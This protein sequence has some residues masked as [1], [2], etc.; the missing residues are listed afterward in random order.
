MPPTKKHKTILL[1]EDDRAL[2]RA[3]VFKLEQDGHKVITTYSAEDALDILEKET[4]HPDIIWLDFLLSGMNGIEFLR[5]IRRRPGLK[6]IKVVICSVSGG[7][8][9][10]KTARDLGVIDY[11]IKSDFNLNKLMDKVVSYA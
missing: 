8:D 11:I 10:E 6:D 3:I 4:T 9:T 2:N 1:V 7:E 5:E